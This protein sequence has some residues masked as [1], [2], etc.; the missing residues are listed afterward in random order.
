LFYEDILL[1]LSFRGFKYSIDLVL[2]PF[3]LL[4]SQVDRVDQSSAL[5]VLFPP[6]L[7]LYYFCGLNLC[8][9][10]FGLV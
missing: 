4:N 3:V 6:C 10:L 2:H 7:F 1:V 5:F 9:S 8:L